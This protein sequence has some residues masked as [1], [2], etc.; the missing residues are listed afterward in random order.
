[1]DIN[2]NTHMN[3]SSENIEKIR[4]FEK[5]MNA[6]FYCDGNELTSVYNEVLNKR[7]NVTNCGSCLRQRIKELV[8]ALNNF[9]K[10]IAIENTEEKNDNITGQ[11][12]KVGRKKKE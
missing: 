3:F 8:A 9:E 6:G 5:I 7:V 12:K 11:P 2:G 10:M 4:K 1:M